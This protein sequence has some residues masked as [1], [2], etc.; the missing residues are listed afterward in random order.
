[1][2]NDADI[3]GDD[4]DDDDDQN[5]EIYVDEDDLNR[6]VMSLFKQLMQV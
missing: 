5:E 1:M 3:D 4:V 2:G 6:W